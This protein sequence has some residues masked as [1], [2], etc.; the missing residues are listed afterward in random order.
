MGARG[1]AGVDAVP[2]FL[3]AGKGRC[4]TLAGR[5]SGGGL[6]EGEAGGAALKIRSPW[7]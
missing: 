4:A 2:C 7:V 1:V 5:G 3:A 6:K